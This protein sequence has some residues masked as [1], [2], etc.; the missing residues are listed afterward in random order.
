M[1]RPVGPTVA[2][3]LLLMPP[4][5][6]AQY[7]GDAYA[8]ALPQPVPYVPAPAFNPM[9]TPEW[10]QAGG[11][12]QAWEQLMMQKMAAQEQAA[13]QQQVQAYQEWA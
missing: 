8:S 6:R 12:Y 3:G 11:D 1:A 5:A 9:M 4:I 7:G 2:M 13:F 10:R